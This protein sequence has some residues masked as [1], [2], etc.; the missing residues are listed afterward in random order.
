MPDLGPIAFAL[1][2]RVRLDG[3]G[4]FCCAAFIGDAILLPF[5]KID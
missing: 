4:R 2:G 1:E 5:W 3:K